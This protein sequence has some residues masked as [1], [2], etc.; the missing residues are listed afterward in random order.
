MKIIERLK[1]DLPTSLALIVI[2]G[3]PLLLMGAMGDTNEKESLRSTRACTPAAGT[4]VTVSTT[5]GASAASAQLDESTVYM[6]YCTTT[7]YIAT[8]TSAPTAANTNFPMPPAVWPLR[9]NTTIR[10]FAG[11]AK[12][13]NGTCYLW[14]CQ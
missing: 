3:T 13:T 2:V 8:G 12:T 10:Y 4:P 6:V 14:K 9:T 1:N 5:T 11:R 7:T